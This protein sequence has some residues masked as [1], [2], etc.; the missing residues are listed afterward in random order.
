MK[1][2][3][4]ENNDLQAKINEALLLLDPKGTNEIVTQAM[5]IVY[6][7]FR[8]QATNQNFSANDLLIKADNSINL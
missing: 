5:T 1:S 3:G 2:T 6:E 8:C 4:H 7:G